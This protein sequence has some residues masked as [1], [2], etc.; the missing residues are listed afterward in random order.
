[1]ARTT[2]D[3]FRGTDWLDLALISG[4]L[5]VSRRWR[6]PWHSVPRAPLARPANA[7]K[8]ADAAALPTAGHELG[9]GTAHTTDRLN[10][11]PHNREQNL[12]AVNPVPEQIGMVRLQRAGPPCVAADDLTNRLAFQTQAEYAR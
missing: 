4:S 10:A 9:V 3:R 6:F 5:G 1:M 12:A 7:P 11:G 2:Q 8:R